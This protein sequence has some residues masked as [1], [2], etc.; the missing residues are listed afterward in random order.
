[1]ESHQVATSDPYANPDLLAAI[2]SI[3]EAHALIDEL[4]DLRK[5]RGLSQIKLA[6]L[7]RVSQS[8][9]SGFESESNDPRLSTVQRYARALEVKVSF[10]VENR[11][12][13]FHA[14]STNWVEGAWSPADGGRKLPTW[15][16]RKAE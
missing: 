16:D 10:K 7:M 1:M 5:S 4:V 13:T 15:N 6:G 11:A 9:I 3:E 2:L 8:T 14:N 12:P